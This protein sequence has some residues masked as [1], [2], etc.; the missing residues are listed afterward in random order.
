MGRQRKLLGKVL[1]RSRS[2]QIRSGQA[3]QGRPGKAGGCIA[4]VACRLLYRIH[5]PDL[6]RLIR[7][8]IRLSR[9]LSVVREAASTRAHG[10]A[11][12]V[13]HAAHA[14]EKVRRPD[15]TRPLPL[16][17]S[18]LFSADQPAFCQCNRCRL[19]APE[20]AL[21]HATTASIA[22]VA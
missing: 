11:S 19:F 16:S 9:S 20:V 15:L 1:S 2:G 13:A 17:S 14:K 6:L 12:Q 8:C 21:S 4:C 5:R 18:P 7:Y 22:L 10:Q 3:R